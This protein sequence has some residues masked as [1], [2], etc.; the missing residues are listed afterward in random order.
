MLVVLGMLFNLFLVFN[1][2]IKENSIGLD[3]KHGNYDR[4]LA[5]KRGWNIIQQNCSC[6]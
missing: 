1:N 3:K 4:Y 5:R 6:Y 2:K